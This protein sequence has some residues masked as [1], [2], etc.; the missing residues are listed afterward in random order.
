[1]KYIYICL[2]VLVYACSKEPADPTSTPTSNTDSISDNDTT[3]V[4]TIL[5]ISGFIEKDS[6]FFTNK[7]RATYIIIHSTQVWNVTCTEN[8]I[9]F[10]ATSADSGSI[11]IL[12]TAKHNNFISRTADIQFSSQDSSHTITVVQEGSPKITLTIQG[13]PITL[14]K[15]SGDT[16]IMGDNSLL[17]YSPEHS[18]RLDTYYISTTE[19][20][21]E[22]WYAVTH[23]WPYDSIADFDGHTEYQHMKYPVSAV[24]WYD[25]TELFVPAINKLTQ[26]S[27]RLPTEAEWEY[28]ASGGI[29]SRYTFA[30]SNEIK[31]V[32]WCDLNSEGHKHDV[33]LLD[34]N[35]FGLYDM[36]GNVSEWCQDWYAY[37]Y[38]DENQLLN[39]SNVFN[40]TGPDTGET[41]IV[42]GGNFASQFW[43]AG[44]CNIRYRMSE[45]PNG[46]KGCWGDT[47]N[48]NE[49][50]CFV[51]DNI[52]FRLVLPINN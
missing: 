35:T 11:A 5:D 2:L 8:W 33:A 47:G 43:D 22:L 36:S 21:N 1:M 9:D 46:Y 12:L 15:I 14:K 19:V 29:N 45:V 51:A 37:N 32:A 30:G 10:S 18:V 24:T 25:V 40:P 31:N 17:E 34:T 26:M 41:K 48:E 20:T 23:F 38:V 3:A 44:P 49:P 52:G 6:I 13:I 16:F 39:N 28:A 4:D 27:F 50:E 7:T 42:R